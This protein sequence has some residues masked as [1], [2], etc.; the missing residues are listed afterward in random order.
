MTE[1]TFYFGAV[2]VLDGLICCVFVWSP[3]RRGI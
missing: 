3:R 2:V 1:L